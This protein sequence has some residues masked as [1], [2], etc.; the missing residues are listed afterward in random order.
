MRSGKPGALAIRHHGGNLNAARCAFPDAPEPWIDLSTGINP[1]PYP[2]GAVSR[3]AWTRLPE[4]S[5]HD[6]LEA[7]AR[8]AYGARASAGIVAA[9]GSQALIQWLPRIFPAR[10]VGVLGVTYQEHETCWRAAGAD[11]VTVPALADLAGFDV[12]VVVNPNN[13]DGRICAADDLANMARILARRGGRLIVDEAFMDV[14]DWRAGLIPRLPDAGAMVLRSLGKA[15]G[16]AGVRLGFAVACGDDSA[17]IQA[18]L[19]PWPVSGPALEIGA[20]ALAD[21]AW[22][23]EAVQR[24][25][26]EAARLDRLLQ[27]VGF[28]IVGG[29]PLFRLA[30]HEAADGWFRHLCR[31]GIL[32][33]PFQAR[34][35]W[36]RFGIP[37]A[38]GDWARLETALRAMKPDCKDISVL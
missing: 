24:L 11:V 19:G 32:T 36:L 5:A 20:R 15:Y 21:E 3:A 35:D 28:E 31:A 14:L 29:T 34:P 33:R 25:R 4:A 37:H 10:R 17:R 18:A 6:A 38:A 13:P 27:T 1:V 30:C 7:A 22:L 8:R 26:N 12:G 16:L 2:V 9:A 23:C